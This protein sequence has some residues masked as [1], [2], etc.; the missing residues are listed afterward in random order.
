[1]TQLRGKSLALFFILYSVFWGGCDDHKPKHLSRCWQV[2]DTAVSASKGKRCGMRV[3]RTCQ[4]CFPHLS[5]DCHHCV[6][7]TLSSG[8][9][10]S[11]HA[12]MVRSPAWPQVP[13]KATLA[14]RTNMEAQMLV[15]IRWICPPALSYGS[16]GEEETWQLCRAVI[17]HLWSCST[18]SFAFSTSSLPVLF[19][20]FF[21]TK[22]IVS[23]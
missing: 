11:G 21:C 17:W 15:Y 2:H 18:W 7:A 9:R 10:G 6:L 5:P 22:E 12:G 16:W 1:M 8:L 20:V 23:V 14:D 4:A 13:H 19:P 3:P